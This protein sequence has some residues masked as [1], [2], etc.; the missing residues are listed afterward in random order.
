MALA[1]A[2]PRLLCPALAA[3]QPRHRASPLFPPVCVCDR[4]SA[5][6]KKKNKA[7][8]KKKKAPAKKK[9]PSKKMEEEEEVTESEVEDAS[10]SEGPEE[11]EME[12][13]VEEME[14]MEVEVD[15]EE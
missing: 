15:V 12:E 6:S 7:P 9:K 2:R 5:G 10:E 13:E 3:S 14:G 1:A 4:L 8:T 11:G